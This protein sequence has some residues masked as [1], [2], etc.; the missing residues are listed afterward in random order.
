MHG[1][2]GPVVQELETVGAELPRMRAA[3]P[4]ARIFALVPI[5]A[6]SAVQ[7]RLMVLHLSCGMPSNNLE[8]VSHIYV[9]GTTVG[10]ERTLNLS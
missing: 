10:T 9:L 3:F 4:A 6:S 2:I 1:A 7:V 8:V 5:A